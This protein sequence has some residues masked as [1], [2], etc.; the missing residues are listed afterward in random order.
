MTDRFGIEV[1]VVS[2]P[3]GGMADGRFAAAV[4]A[5]GGLGMV[6]LGDGET[7]G[8]VRAQAALAAEPGTAYGI[9]LLA[10]QLPDLGD[11]LD[12]IREIAPRSSR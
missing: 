2:A 4:C 8:W 7:A 6:G 5:A 10:W 1:P 3:M 9:G 11:H 12:A